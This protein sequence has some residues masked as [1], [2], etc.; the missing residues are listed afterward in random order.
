[1][2]ANAGRQWRWRRC[3]IVAG[4]APSPGTP[5]VASVRPAGAIKAEGGPPDPI[6]IVER[7]RTA[8]RSAAL[9]QLAQL[10]VCFGDFVRRGASRIK[11]FEGDLS[12]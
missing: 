4:I 3:Q 11:R 7:L 2:S 8:R 6:K 12:M 5:F 9:A 1:M 10:E